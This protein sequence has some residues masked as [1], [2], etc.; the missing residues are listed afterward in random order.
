MLNQ[1][2]KFSDSDNILQS[3][4]NISKKMN[5]YF[6]PILSCCI[7][8][9]TTCI[10]CITFYLKEKKIDRK[11]FLYFRAVTQTLDILFCLATIM[12]PYINE[13][14]LCIAQGISLSFINSLMAQWNLIILLKIYSELKGKRI[15]IWILIIVAIFIAIFSCIFTLL[16][17]SFGPD[18]FY[19]TFEQQS[20]NSLT[21]ILA[22]SINFL[23][24]IIIIVFLSKIYKIVRSRLQHKEG[25]HDYLLNLIPFPIIFGVCN[26]VWI[27][28]RIL[29]IFSNK[30]ASDYL[31]FSMACCFSRTHG[32]VNGLYSI[33]L[34][35]I[36]R[37]EIKS[38]N[39]SIDSYFI[40]TLLGRD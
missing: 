26:F 30:F 17:G 8:S 20:S 33:W 34:Y 27:I 36:K 12:N 14:E 25:L 29:I 5:T 38:S 37:N 11:M 2:S 22:N 7:A 35:K 19:C 13:G 32:L 28:R 24:I 18:K 1:L 3:V 39:E 10:V 23:Y 40:N 9:I 15:R 31:L 16:S 6:I 21:I 4:E